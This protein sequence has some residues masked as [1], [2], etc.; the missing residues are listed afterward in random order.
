MSRF[1][2]PQN[3]IALVGSDQ[4]PA[5]GI[6]S[7][8]QHHARVTRVVNS[9]VRSAARLPVAIVPLPHLGFHVQQAIEVCA[10]DPVIGVAAE[11]RSEVAFRLVQIAAL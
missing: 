7:N 2:V 6:D 11:S 10:G 4:L 3:S 8:S 9:F 1:R 5:A